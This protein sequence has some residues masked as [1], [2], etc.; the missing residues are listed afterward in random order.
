MTAT[1][2][3]TGLAE[4]LGAAL[5]EVTG[6]AVTIDALAPLGGGACQD[7]YRVSLT[8]A[9]GPDAGSHP[10]VFRSDAARSL[11]GSIARRDEFAVI[12]AARAAGV[13]TPRARW[14]LEGVVAPG[15]SAYLLDWV[16]GEAIGRRVVKGP[17]L[18]AA[19]AG[20]VEELAGELAKIH[21]ITPH[22]AP[23][24]AG[25][26]MVS[27][28]DEDP[29]ES[30]LRFLWT[31]LDR[32]PEPHPAIAFAAAWM[33]QHRPAPVAPT[34]V[35]GDF[36]TGNFMVAPDDLRAVLDW[37]FAHWGDPMEDVAWLCVRD[38]RFGELSLAA[39]GFATREAFVRAY[40]R[41][42]GVTV[43]PAR[44]RWWEI[45]GNAR[46]AAGSVLQGERYLSGDESDLELLAIARRAAEM[47]WEALRL[48]RG[49]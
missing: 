26:A 11:M 42:R 33:A 6:V 46:W 2:D 40:E 39:G 22:G 37:E 34:L 5:R 20:L 41:A 48:I 25:I 17:A 49:G 15:R 23:S 16:E 14:L 8:L 45:M 29:C 4:R 27:G 21:G 31:M 35:H 9:A 19:R 47:E 32:L 24:L 30:A 10:L 12:S 43:D 13:R 28:P 44:V 38:W 36:R 18:A 7:N 3:E 1:T